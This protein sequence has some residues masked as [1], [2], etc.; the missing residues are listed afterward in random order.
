MAYLAA[1]LASIGP[2]VN[3]PG[4]HEPQGQRHP[5]PCSSVCWVPPLGRDGLPPKLGPNCVILT[6]REAAGLGELTGSS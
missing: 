2:H 1:M 3:W 5:L 4:Q 6:L